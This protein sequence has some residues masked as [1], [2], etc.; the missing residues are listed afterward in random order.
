MNR[1]DFLENVKR[2]L[3]ASYLP[4]ARAQRPL[5][6]P[7]SP[8]IPADLISQFTQE[9]EILRSNIY[10]VNSEADVLSTIVQIFEDFQTREYIAWAEENLPV[11]NLKAR[12]TAH[13]LTEREFSI[14]NYPA[15]RT[16]TLQSLSDVQ[17]GITGALAGLA[18]T[19]SLVIPGG[20]GKSRLASLLPIVHIALLKADDLFP[21]LAHFVDAHP[22]AAR[23]TANL[24][25]IS[26]PSR[27][28]D[29]EQTLTLGVHG[30]KFVHIILV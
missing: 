7:L 28:A 11:P 20:E 13:G 5:S 16:K 21:T 19:G 9:A 25:I 4:D 29:I 15:A 3:D 2:S 23:D 27:T 24:N 12:L 22:N 10:R 17:I 6:P 18:D 26:G 14:S 30:P 1:N 8:F